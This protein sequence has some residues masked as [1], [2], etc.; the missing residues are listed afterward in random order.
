MTLEFEMLYRLIVRG[1][2][3]RTEGSPRGARE[4][5]EMSEAT[6]AGPR[7]EA[8]LGMPGGDWMIY[9]PDGFG[10]P[11]VRVQFVTNDDALILLHYTGLV[12]RTPAFVQAAERGGETRW[13]DQYMRMAMTFDTGDS[14]YRWLNQ[15][16]FVAEG[17]LAGA[18]TIEYQIYRIG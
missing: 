5:W 16:L 10:R 12:E 11:D 17:R 1:P 9:G 18:N 8:R 6:L 14:R 13:Q 7:I 15:H 3:G 4:Y 2:L